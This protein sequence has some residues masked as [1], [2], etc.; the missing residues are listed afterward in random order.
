MYVFSD[1]TQLGILKLV[2]SFQAILIPYIGLSD[3]FLHLV[4]WEWE[5]GR[6]LI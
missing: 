4:F 2:E 5:F 6:R 1:S 3:L